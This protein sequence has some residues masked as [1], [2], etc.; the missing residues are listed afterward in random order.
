MDETFDL[1]RHI[2]DTELVDFVEPVCLRAG[3]CGV[4]FHLIGGAL[5][6]RFGRKALMVWPRVVF[7][8]LTLPG[9]AW[10][11]AARTAPVLIGVTAVLTSVASLSAGVALV[12]L[13]EAIPKPVRSGSLAIVYAIAI[14][15]FN[16]TA[17]L[18][19][20]WLVKATGDVLWPAYYMAAFTAVGIVAMAMMRE[21]APVRTGTL[22]SR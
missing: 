4:V 20:T 2:H 12:A 21:T 18:V 7:L 13:T 9:F 6:D 15:V 3:A 1:D 5:S 16:G 14:A 8:V 22:T 17:Q 10:I 11:A 19:M